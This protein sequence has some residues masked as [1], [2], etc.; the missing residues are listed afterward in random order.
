G[1]PILLSGVVLFG[2]EVR[3][4]DGIGYLI[5]IAGSFWYMTL[6]RADRDYLEKMNGIADDSTRGEGSEKNDAS[7]NKASRTSSRSPAPGRSMSGTTTGRKA[8]KFHRLAA[9]DEG[10][11]RSAAV[12]GNTPTG[13][14]LDSSTS[15]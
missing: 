3:L 5:C 6:V 15:G 12:A 1:I 10:D 13:V 9:S 4:F 2:D 14:H 7:P 8:P 11:E